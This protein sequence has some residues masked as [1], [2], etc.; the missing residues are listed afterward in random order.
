M[1]VEADLTGLARML[2]PREES[3]A[4]AVLIVPV[5]PGAGASTIAAGLVRVAA[6]AGSV[7]LYDL[8]FG[9]N[10]HA[11]RFPLN[12]RAYDGALGGETFWRA[13]P[14]GSSRLAM[15]RCAG[16]PVAVSRFER[17]PGSV[18]RV[19]FHRASDYWARARRKARL[20]L[21]DAPGDLVAARALAADM[22]GVILVAD[23]R[24]HG[25]DDAARTAA[26]LEQAG[27]RVLGLVVN[28]TAGR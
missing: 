2:D 6:R 10:R 21:A 8:D 24:R 17:E 7:W 26:R 15:R 9:G 25:R 14:D 27:G 28:R 20:V 12:G 18:R 23:A 22:D 13:E 11:L 5:A 16:A 4:R 1:A 19:T 3:L